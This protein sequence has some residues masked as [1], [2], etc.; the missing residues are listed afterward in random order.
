ME[1]TFGNRREL[2]GALKE[3][4][5][6]KKLKLDKSF[7]EQGGNYQHLQ[8]EIIEPYLSAFGMYEQRVFH[9]P[10][11]LIRYTLEN[12]ISQ[13]EAITDLES[14]VSKYTPE[15][16]KTKTIIALKRRKLAAR[17]AEREAE[18]H[19]ANIHPTLA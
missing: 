4:L 10:R 16:S 14:E 2:I 7:S 15:S 12:G 9:T 8:R 19:Y 13:E 1:N 5:G 17:R 18:S 11:K 6:V 3:I